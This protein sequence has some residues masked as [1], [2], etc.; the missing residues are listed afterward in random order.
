MS[1]AGSEVAAGGA[2]RGLGPLR[3]RDGAAEREGRPVHV[4]GQLTEGA[5]ADCGAGAGGVSEYRSG[6]LFTAV[7]TGVLAGG[8]P[9][10]CGCDQRRR[11]GP[12]LDRH[13]GAE[14]GEMDVCALAGAEDPLPR[15]HGRRGVRLLRR[16]GEARP[17]LVA[18]PRPRMALPSAQG[19]PP[20]VAALRGG[21]C[22]VSEECGT[23][24]ARNLN[25]HYIC[26]DDFKF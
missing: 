5:G 15:G 23:G 19:A 3:V 22:D 14:A 21:E 4:H 25:I 20:H 26:L 1:L 11:P 17:A 2:C 9:R 6:D 10:D 8:E 7:Q 24:E 13:D 18:D 12:A 16:Y